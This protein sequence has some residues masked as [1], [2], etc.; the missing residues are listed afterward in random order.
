MRRAVQSTRSYP[1]NS[2]HA[3]GRLVALAL[4]SNGE[5]KAVEWAKLREIGAGARLGLAGQE[6]HDIVDGLCNDLLA[7]AAT[8]TSCLVD[9][10]TMARW[11]DELDDRELQALVVFLSA[12][13]IFADGRVDPGESALLRVAIERWGPPGTTG[14]A[15]VGPPATGAVHC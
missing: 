11:F 1:R 9:R 12:E 3:A 10:K 7:T 5:I 8:R 15:S 2:P 6:W 13:L 14:P 4:I